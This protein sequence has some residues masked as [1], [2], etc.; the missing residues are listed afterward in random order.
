VADQVSSASEKT[1]D[2]IEREMLCT[3]EALTEKVVALES[4]VVGTAHS[5]TETVSGTVEAVKSFVSAAPETVSETVRNAADAVKERVMEAFD[6]SGHVRRNPWAALG[7]SAAAGC[8]VGYFLFGNGTSRVASRM[9]EA[10]ADGSAYAPPPPPSYAASTP[11]RPG[12][13]DE[14]LG[15][16]GGKAKELARTALES[17]SEAVKQSI[18]T[19]VPQIVDQASARLTDAAACAAGSTGASSFAS[20]FEARRGRA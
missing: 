20:E 12:V 15:M 3:R 5:I 8:V 2:E 11:S 18:Q 14:L 1:P 6:V 19:R 10:S 9:S 16:V 7:A 13:W 4:Q 17:V